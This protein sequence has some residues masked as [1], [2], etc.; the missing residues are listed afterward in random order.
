MTESDEDDVETGFT[1]LAG[2][3]RDYALDN[4]PETDHDDVA[5]AS[6][7]VEDDDV[8][9]LLLFGERAYQKRKS[10]EDTPFW[11]TEWAQVR[12]RRYA[13]RMASRAIRN[14]NKSQI[15]YLIGNV[16]QQN[17]VSGLH[18][19]RKL[20]D[21]LIHSENCKLI[22]LA[23]LMGRG[24]TDWSLSMC[25]VVHWHYKRLRE[26]VKTAGGKAS[27]VPQ[28]EFAANF[29]VGP[30]PDGVE[31]EHIDNYDDLVEWSE[32]G[33][34]DDVRW[35]IF[36]E[37][38]TELTAQ[39]GEVAQDVAKLMAPFVKKMRKNG[40]NMIVVGHD[41]GDIHVAIR[42]LAD[43]VSKPGLK[44]AT[45]YQGIKSRE[46]YGELFALDK[47]PE[48]TW[49]FDT[50]DT[51]EWSWGS[52]LDDDQEIDHTTLKRV[53]ALTAA[54]LVEEQGISQNQ[55][56][57]TVSRE[58]TGISRHMVRQALRGEYSEVSETI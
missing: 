10:P 4:I 21:W 28:P 52:A 51:A 42:S 46:P 20:E 8:L 15:A 26:T 36:D 43:F 31:C 30:E 56:V 48:T 55:A 40:I 57:E 3:L 22:Y 18:T 27:E 35:F 17:D 45:V 38:S 47:I 53:L 14:G 34:S 13:S 58:N 49:D 12:V 32:K 23:G 2:D 6:A 9:D 44:K 25:Q 33:D 37:A 29:Y 7:L 11:A 41:R 50:D 1:G 54:D 5:K 16:D 39:S 24:K 19:I